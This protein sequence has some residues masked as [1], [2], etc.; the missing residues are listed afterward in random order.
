VILA[1]LACKALMGKAVEKAKEK[2]VQWATERQIKK[3]QRELQKQM[4][5]GGGKDESE[6]ESES[7]SEEDESPE[8]LELQTKAKVKRAREWNHEGAAEWR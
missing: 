7:E 1:A 2:Y 3:W 5:N 8:T 6:S 4:R